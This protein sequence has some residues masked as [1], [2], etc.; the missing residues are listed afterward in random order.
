ML[1]QALPAQTAILVQSHGGK[2]PTGWRG[3]FNKKLN[4]FADGFIFTALQQGLDWFGTKATVHEKKIF[5]A[6]EGSTYFTATDRAVAQNNTGLTGNPIY[7]WIGTLD[8][9]KSPLT[10]LSGFE[11]IAAENPSA[12]LYMI[13]GNDELLPAVTAKL[14]ASPRLK[15]AVTLVGKVARHE[16]GNYL[17]SAHYFVLGSHY[18]G[19]G[20]SLC[21]ALACGCV[22]I[23]T[24]IPSFEMMTDHGALGA[25]WEPGNVDSFVAAAR[26]ATQKN[27]PTESA[28]CIAHFNRE[29]S[30]PAIAQK[31][32]G[33]YSTVVGRRAA[34]K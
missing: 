8:A 20:Y 21:E 28:K 10:V 22:P 17:N 1:R 5:L 29:L 16:I 31:A 4:A 12:R 34:K 14:N 7:I 6:M 3:A 24:D 30:F 2:V 18:E 32:I 19:S 13:Y 25:L 33:Y 15:N 23:V 26:K 11:Y 9:N 27:W